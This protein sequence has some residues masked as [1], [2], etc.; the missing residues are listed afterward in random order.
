MPQ[1][2]RVVFWD[3]DGTLAR[4]KDRWSGALLDAW[5]YVDPTIAATAAQ[6]RPYL[7]AG[8]PWHDP[9]TVRPPQ[10]ADQ[11]W[12]ALQPLFVTALTENGLGLEL[13][14]HVVARVPAEF[15]RVDAWTVIDGA[16]DAL[17]I[18]KAA[19]YRNVILSNHA[20]ELPAL[21]EALGF[22]ELI[23]HTITSA[24]VGAEKPNRA[25]FDYALNL[26]E[27][28]PTSDIWMVGDNPVA[29]VEGAR[30]AG[31][32]PIL[33]DGAYADSRGVTVLEAARL[34]SESSGAKSTPETR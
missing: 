19:G 12:A 13:A 8:F 16:I 34:V 24:V 17:A 5:R 30:G 28:A 2:D 32:R 14:E 25:I 23:E 4:R 21:V 20:P 6:L 11:W 27:L 33:A 3:F 15:Y 26:F 31:I 7:S 10:S 22:S 1:S 29:D 18:T 9:T